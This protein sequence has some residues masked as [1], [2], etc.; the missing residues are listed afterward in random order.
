M[1]HAYSWHRMCCMLHPFHAGSHQGYA[2]RASEEVRN[3]SAERMSRPS[4]S[5]AAAAAVGSLRVPIKEY[6]VPT[7]H[8]RPHDPAVAPDGALWV[9]EQAANKLGRLD[10]ETA[11]FKEYP[12]K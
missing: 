1:R 10:P 7:P 8:A 3:V 6:D 5:V 2:W 11:K 9:T 4:L 12:L